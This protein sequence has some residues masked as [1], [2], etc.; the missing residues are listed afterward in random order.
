MYDI[1][2]LHNIYIYIVFTL[3]VHACISLRRVWAYLCSANMNQEIWQCYHAID[4]GKLSYLNMAGA[5]KTYLF[6]I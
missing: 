4:Q 1:L 2:N 3:T 6:V 5:N